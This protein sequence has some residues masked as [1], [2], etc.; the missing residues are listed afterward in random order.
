MKGVQCTPREPRG[1]LAQAGPLLGVVGVLS[2]ADAKST[3]GRKT[4][5]SAERPA[6]RSSEGEDKT[7]RPATV[8]RDGDD[9]RSDQSGAKAAATPEAQSDT[10][11]PLEDV[12]DVPKLAPDIELSGEAQDGAFENSQ[13]LVQRNG[14][15]VQLTELLYRVLEGVDGE[16]DLA[17][18]ADSV[19]NETGRGVSADNVRQ[20]LA[21]K[22]IPMGL[23]L[24]AD[25]TVAASANVDGP[26]S[27]LAV[28][29]RMAM[30]GPR[31]IDPFTLVLQHLFAPPILIVVLLIAAVAHGWL[32]FVHGIASGLHELLYS[33]GLLL[34]VLGVIVLSTAFHEFGHA[35]A[36]RYG[37]GKVRGMG[38]GMY[39]VYPAFYT[40]VTDNYRLGRWARV[41]TDLGGFYFNLIFGT[42]LIALYFAT[43][44][45]FLLLIVV[46][47]MLEI[48]HQVLPFVRLDGYWAL[49]DLTGIPDFFSHIGPFLRTVLPLPFWKG[50]K[51]PPVKP[52]VKVVF[53]L[54]I[55]VT[56]PLL[57]FILFMMLR[58]VPRVLATAWDS[59]GQQVDSFQAAQGSGD[60]LGMGAAGAQ[61]ILLLI[62]TFG[63]VYVVAKL[64]KQLLARIWTWSKPSAGRRVVGTFATT[65]IVALLALLWL[66]SIPF[67]DGQRGPISVRAGYTPIGP[68]E[69]GTVSDAGIR[70]PVIRPASNRSNNRQ[71]APEVGT[72]TATASATGTVATTQTPTAAG[73]TTA[74]AGTTTTVTAT[75]TVTTSPTP[76]QTVAPSPTP[77]VPAIV[78]TEP[79]PA[80]PTLEPTT[81]TMPDPTVTPT[82]ENA[83]S[84]PTVE[85]TPTVP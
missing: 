83:A 47:I 41:R 18:I 55:L 70:I 2:M 74:T 69:R 37:G 7:G 28:N 84:E 20:L 46:F 6:G 51:L 9:S 71:D 67:G 78:P 68:D 53:G 40:D 77:T 21:Q 5:A 43:G 8:D 60:I 39:L 15:F 13:W 4:P 49:A 3:F 73:T 57:F 65:A 25:G 44:M 81:V 27:P 23:V 35:A 17:G 32:F 36:L 1:G 62:P 52:W 34:A 14:R 24:Q 75:T 26:R 64:L 80:E 58:S 48:V 79:P 42:G 10:S 30:V 63:L 61:A 76:T 56:I 85:P 19:S 82:P 16:H 31:F 59:F 38:A 11:I 66:P 33:P 72:G 50:R 12:P 29:M 54:Y 45:D 22:L